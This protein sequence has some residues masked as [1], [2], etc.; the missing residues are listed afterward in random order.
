MAFLSHGGSF[1]CE[2]LHGNSWSMS[3]LTGL[4]LSKTPQMHLFKSVN[5][6]HSEAGS[7][8]CLVTHTHSGC[9]LHSQDGEGL[10]TRN[11]R[12]HECQWIFFKFCMQLPW[13]IS[14]ILPKFQL[15][16]SLLEI[17]GD[18]I[19]LLIPPNLPAP[20]LQWTYLTL[21]MAHQSIC[22]WSSKFIQHVSNSLGYTWR[23]FGCLLVPTLRPLDD[24]WCLL[25][26]LGDF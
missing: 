4:A 24:F 23:L 9:S 13:H 21:C 19:L 25:V 3:P 20:Y 7:R 1:L 18:I 16:V 11:E 17:A 2:T 5:L 12:H 26:S 10:D 8:F 22:K 14:C 6:R 15:C